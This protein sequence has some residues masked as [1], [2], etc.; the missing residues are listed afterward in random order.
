MI[1]G[2]VYRF[3]SISTITAPTTAIAMIMAIVEIVK[4][5]P[6]GACGTGVDSGVAAGASVA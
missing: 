6:T 4:Y 3:L 5:I 1:V 2:S